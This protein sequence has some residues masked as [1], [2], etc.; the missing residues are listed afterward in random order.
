MSTPK[1]P[2]AYQGD[3]GIAVFGVPYDSNSSYRRGPALAPGKIREALYC[4]SS[5][6][7]TED[8][9]NLGEASNW[10][11]EPD[12]NILDEKKPFT[13]I[14]SEVDKL[15]KRKQRVVTLGGDHSI[16]LPVIRAYAKT[17]KKLSILHLDAHPDLYVE[18]GGNRYSHACPFAR[19]MEEQLAVKLVQVGIRTLTG[20]QHEQAKRFEVE[21]IQ[22]KNI[23]AAKNISF[24]GPVYLSVDLDCL[25][26]AFAPGVS[27][28][29]PGGMSTRDVLDIVQNLKGNLVGGD[30]V[31]YNPDR[32]I[33][34]M[35]GMVAGKLL[36]EIISRML[37]SNDAEI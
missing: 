24:D 9:V 36:K 1:G 35:T 29:E 22:M 32:D 37:Q 12:I 5:N 33:N 14:E 17:Y 13:K 31:E 19:I 4:D 10:H 7:W 30:I 8:L 20:H 16:T 25:D 18:L 2:K 21:Q 6:L 23:S 3:N 28:H 34:G 27:H 11:F 15:L 26:P